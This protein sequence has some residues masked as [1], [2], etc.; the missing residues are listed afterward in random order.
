MQRARSKKVLRWL[1]GIDEAGR[2]PLAGPVSVAALAIRFNDKQILERGRVRDS[3]QLLENAREEK[4]I[5]LKELYNQGKIKYAV[6]LVG[7]RIIDRDGIVSAVKRGIRIV[8][9]RL[10]IQ[11]GE[12][13]ILL[14][15]GI[16][17]PKKYRNQKTII[18][19]DA[20]VAII[21]YASII[22]K[23]T[24]DQKM[25][26]LALKFPKY[27]LHIHKGYGTASHISKIK[28]YGLCPIH[29]RSFVRNIQQN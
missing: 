6:S 17:A 27:D 1:V 16:K 24:R 12:V 23:V 10:H 21:A 13:E 9:A 3:K 29:R 8:L 7:N 11:A 18:G 22:A 5:E 2:G 28:K 19:G 14:D 26:R 15:G 20:K 4:L 25:K